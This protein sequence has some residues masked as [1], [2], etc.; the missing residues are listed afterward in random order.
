VKQIVTIQG[1]EISYRVKS[2]SD[3]YGGTCRGLC[4][5]S[6]Y[7]SHPCPLVGYTVAP[8]STSTSSNILE[9]ENTEEQTAYQADVDLAA[10]G[11]VIDLEQEEDDLRGLD[12][13]EEDDDEQGLEDDNEQGQE[14]DEVVWGQ[15]DDEVGKQEQGSSSCSNWNCSTCTFTNSVFLA[16][17]E[18]CGSKRG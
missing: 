4:D 18:L 9:A 10:S 11:K 15:E 3:L 13:D 12:E 2:A 8:N 16:E 7:S 1:V 14:D 17:C 5:R 6:R